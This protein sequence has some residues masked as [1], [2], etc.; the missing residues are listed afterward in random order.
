MIDLINEM[1][2]LNAKYLV[3]GQN[4][5]QYFDLRVELG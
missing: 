3:G 4:I 2:T 5:L 1:Q